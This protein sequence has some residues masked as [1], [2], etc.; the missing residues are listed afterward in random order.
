[1]TT[2]IPSNEAA[3]QAALARYA[4]LD[5]PPE[6]SFERITALAARLFEVPIALASLIDHQRQWFKSCIGMDAGEMDRQNAFCAHTIFSEA[7]M[8]VPDALDDPRFQDNPQVTGAPHIRFYAGAP[9]ITSDGLRL[10][11]LCIL[12]KVARTFTPA[13][14]AV[15]ADGK[16]F[17]VEL[18]ITRIAAS[19]PPIFTGHIR[20]I[21]ARRAIEALRQSQQE[22]EAARAEAERANLAKSEFLSRM[23]HELRTP[24]N[25]ILGFGELLEMDVKTDRQREKVEHKFRRLT[26]VTPAVFAQMKEAAL[27]GEPPSSHPAGGGRRGPKPKLGIEDRLLVLLM[28]YREYRTFAHTG[29]NRSAPTV[30]PS[31]CMSIDRQ[32]PK[33]FRASLGRTTK[34]TYA[35]KLRDVRWKRRRDEL[36]RRA[37]YTCCECGQPLTS[38]TMDLQVHHVVYISCLDPWD[39]PDELLLV[40]CDCHHKE[41]QAVEQAIYAEVGKHLDPSLILR[42]GL[43]ERNHTVYERKESNR[44]SLR[45]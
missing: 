39:Y 8:I 32:P 5:T 17:P 34:L 30:T 37:N 23:S 10:G 45:P 1:M 21:S 11:S 29:A 31:P 13:Q 27:A 43:C 42:T 33:E 3:R 40:V 12:D 19:G 4:I 22:A 35:E 2:L 41:R 28:Y 7:V 38:G 36:I 15:R 44:A 26:G 25:A 24:L 6:A 16:E 9:L 18:A 14:A 20:D